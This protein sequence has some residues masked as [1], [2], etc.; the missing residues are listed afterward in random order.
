MEFLNLILAFSLIMIALSTVVSGIVESILRLRAI[1]VTVLK[2]AIV[3]LCKD[4][5][6]PDLQDP[7]ELVDELI[8][9]PV[10]K[11]Q[12]D[13]RYW[14]LWFALTS[15]KTRGVVDRLSS[16]AF[17]Q[18]LAKTDVGVAIAGERDKVS[19]RIKDISLSFERYMAATSEVFRKQAHYVAVVVSVILAFAANIEISRTVNYLRDHPDTVKQILADQD[20][21]LAAYQETQNQ[22]DSNPE[23]AAD[24]T[25][26][27]LKEEIDN[28]RQSIT[29]IQET[30]KLPMGWG[31]FP[32]NAEARRKTLAKAQEKKAA[33]KYLGPEYLV[34]FLNVLAAGFLIGLGGPFWYRIFTNLSQVTQLMRTL[35]GPSA[36]SVG[37]VTTNDHGGTAMDRLDNLVNLFEIASGIGAQTATLPPEESG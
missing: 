3:A 32:Y 26:E 2:R 14:N 22:T 16:E 33:K 9:N 6:Q 27:E 10:A 37:E 30:Y 21:I 4:V 15:S 1:R 36:E 20:K 7:S 24:S 13:N 19:D 17:V 18:R 11:D 23:G 31:E 29:D 34:W 12:T 35:N 28:I 25:A 8:K 5:I